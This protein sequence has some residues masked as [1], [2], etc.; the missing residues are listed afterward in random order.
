MAKHNLA[1]DV[2]CEYENQNRLIYS[3]ITKELF[4]EEINDIQIPG[5]I[6]NFI[7]EEFHPNEAHDI[8]EACLDFVNMFLNKK[9][10]F[11]K[12]YHYE[13]VTNHFEINAFRK[14]FKKFKILHYNFEN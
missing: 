5:M 12:E 9:S 7:Y 2:I 11:Y 6:T 4:Y 14:L 1:L 13:D 10:D 8:K 3:F